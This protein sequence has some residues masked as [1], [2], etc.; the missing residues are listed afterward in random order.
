MVDVGYTTLLGD[1]GL[2]DGRETFSL[3]CPH[4]DVVFGRLFSLISYSAHGM[5]HI[6]SRAIIFG[7]IL[8]SHYSC[9]S[10]YCIKS[11]LILT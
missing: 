11:H 10:Q 7:I 4:V 2:A 5:M 3:E 1:F 8:L 6:L 9:M